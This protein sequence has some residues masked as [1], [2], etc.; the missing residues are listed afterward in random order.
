MKA[1]G[2]SNSD[3][4]NVIVYQTGISRDQTTAKKVVDSFFSTKNIGTTNKAKVVKKS[5]PIKMTTKS[6][7]N[8]KSSS[9]SKQD[10]IKLKTKS[11][12]ANDSPKIAAA[13]AAIAAASKQS[14]TKIS[15]GKTFSLGEHM[16]KVN[17]INAEG[18]T[19]AMNKKGSTASRSNNNRR[20]SQTVKS[21]TKKTV[22]TA[23]K[24]R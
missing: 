21:N 4:A 12:A 24:K 6:S 11:A 5:S 2:K 1:A 23:T 14:V 13:V 22:A 16:Q 19:S 17:N 20:T 18:K 9:Q 3:I 7:N 10:P 8:I 15:Q